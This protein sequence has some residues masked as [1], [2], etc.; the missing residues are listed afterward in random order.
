MSVHRYIWNVLAAICVKSTS[1]LFK[2][3]ISADWHKKGSLREDE[4]QNE[5][6]DAF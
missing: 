2:N 1:F 6:S 3:W 4:Q 5:P